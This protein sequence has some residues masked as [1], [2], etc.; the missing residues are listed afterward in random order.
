[1][2]RDFDGFIIYLHNKNIKDIARN[3][4]SYFFSKYPSK[5]NKL[6]LHGYINNITLEIL[7]K[8]AKNKKDEQLIS[9]IKEYKDLMLTKRAEKEAEKY[10]L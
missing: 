4:Q 5:V 8:F 6:N 9:M 10:N 2:I 3:I 7:L 1:M